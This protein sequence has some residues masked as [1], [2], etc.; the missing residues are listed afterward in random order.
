MN[1][2]KIIILGTTALVERE[3][4]TLNYGDDNCIV[5][6]E[7]LLDELR[8]ISLNYTERGKNAKK[9][10]DYLDAF[11]NIG[12][13]YGDGVMQKNC[14]ILRIED[15]KQ[16]VRLE[17]ES[18]KRL[19]L[20]DRERIQIAYGLA[21]KEGKT[22]ILVTTNTA[23]R[24][25]AKRITSAL[26][27]KKAKIKVQAIRNNIFPNLE[28]QY[29]GRIN[30]KVSKFN[31]DKFYNQKFL[32][33]KDVYQSSS[34]EWYPNMFLSMKCL[35]DPQITA[36]GRYDGENI[37]PLLY[38]NSHPYG[39]VSKKEGQLMVLEALMMDADIAPLVIVKGTAGTGKT[40]VSVAAALEQTINQKLYERILVTVPTQH[41]SDIGY[42]PGDLEQKMNPRLEGIIDNLN[43]ISRK[44]YNPEK[45][46]KGSKKS[47]NSYSYHHKFQNDD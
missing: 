12:A 9:V 47:K 16:L 43:Q 41:V 30:C 1:Y 40:Y 8:K 15:G 45:E 35:E 13:L 4:A 11:N 18:L 20:I 44:K 27:N 21:E 46:K 10:L 33:K 32:R 31:L 17:D 39:F 34:F 2:K 36:I 23:L 6:P 29:K 42:L 19:S 38:S 14:S 22:T 5:I 37:V 24:I 3:N 26:A 7:V 28:D 25:K